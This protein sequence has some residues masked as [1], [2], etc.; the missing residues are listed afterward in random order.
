M[1]A[2]FLCLLIL[3]SACSSSDVPE[4]HLF[5]WADY[6]KPDLI[7]RFEKEQRC[8]VVIDTYDSNE[9]MYA[10]L[11]LG[12]TGYDLIFPSSYIFSI[13][14]EQNMLESFDLE[15]VPNISYLDNSYLTKFKM[16]K[17]DYGIPYMLSFTGL[18]YRQDK[19]QNFD[20]TWSVFGQRALKGRM[21]MLNDMRETMGAALLYL[22]YNINTQKV[23]EIKKAADQLISWKQ[24]LAKFENE[25]YKNGIATA[26]F[27]VVQGY[28]GDISQVIEENQ[29]VAFAYPKEGTAFS[30]DLVAIPKNPPNKQLAEKFV[31]FLLL[32]EVAAENIQF[33]QFPSPNLG[34]YKLLG[35]LRNDPAI[36]PPKEVLD[37]SQLIDQV[38]EAIDLYIREWDRAKAE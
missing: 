30:I 34:A 11:K 17:I 27:L 18:G 31:N 20:P 13:M 10:K 19:F 5:M 14:K 28:N 16:E 38:G 7:Y 15:K 12:V 33:T 3:L 36:F 8:R 21:T 23:E 37:K 32:P 1:K 25:Q 29:H 6:I 4:L 2:V 35:D 9:A 26:E 24:N 22:G